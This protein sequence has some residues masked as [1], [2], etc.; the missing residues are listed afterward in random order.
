MFKQAILFTVAML[1]VAKASEDSADL[2]G[3]TIE[4]ADIES[5]IQ[6]STSKTPEDRGYF[7]SD[8]YRYNLTADQKLS[9]LWPI[10]VPDEND[11]SVEPKSQ[12]FNEFD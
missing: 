5:L 2:L 7:R 8:H 3:D 1:Q 12:M 11:H 6:A 10:L 9:E 4:D